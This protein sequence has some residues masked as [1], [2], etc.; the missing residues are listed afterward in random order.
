MLP[1]ICLPIIQ[2][3]FSGE[4]FIRGMMTNMTENVKPEFHNSKLNIKNVKFL[5]VLLIQ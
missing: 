1:I 2:P 5:H 3:I 4:G